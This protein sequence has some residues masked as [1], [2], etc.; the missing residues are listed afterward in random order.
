VNKLQRLKSEIQRL[1]EKQNLANLV[2]DLQKYNTLMTNA[3]E[4]LLLTQDRSAHIKIVS[5]DIDLKSVTG[6]IDDIAKTA[7]RLRKRLSEKIENIKNDDDK[8]AIIDGTTKGASTL[9]REKWRTFLQSK[10]EVYEKLVRAAAD[11]NLSG[12]DRLTQTLNKLRNQADSL[13]E[14]EEKARN[15]ASEL[16]SISDSIETLGLKGKVGD[17]L[18]AAANGN[19]TAQM[20]LE[21]EVQ[22]FIEH[23]RLWSA[24]SVRLG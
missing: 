12:S 15:I 11:A 14:S 18:T 23:N 8:V 9:L 7:Q 13:P 6:K 19:A 2:G 17:F 3:L 1:P 5:P 4:V 22:Q 24:L 16:E 10:I 21:T 20:L